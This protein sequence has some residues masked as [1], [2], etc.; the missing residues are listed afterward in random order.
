[1]FIAG[2]VPTHTYHGLPSFYNK[3]VK[4]LK[5]LIPLTIFNPIWQQQAASHHTKRDTID[6]ASTDKRRYTGLPAP[7]EWSQSCAQWS[8]NYQSFVG[9]L[10]DLY[11][12]PTILGWFQKH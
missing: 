6:Q 2:K 5:G 8:Q 12:M 4:A 9:A 7:G 1:L 10:K 11:Q 3:N